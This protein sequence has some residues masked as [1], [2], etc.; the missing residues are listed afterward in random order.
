MVWFWG[1]IWLRTT[2]RR[3][4]LEQE[5]L[6]YITRQLQRHHRRPGRRRARRPARSSIP[7]R[8]P[9]GP[10]AERRRHLDGRLRRRRG[11][12]RRASSPPC[13]RPILLRLVPDLPDDVQG[14]AD[15]ADLRGGGG[16]P[17][18]ARPAALR[19]LLAQHRRS[20]P[21]L[22]RRDRAHQLHRRRAEYGGKHFVYLSKYMEPDH[23]Y[24]TMPEE[25][26]DRDV[27]AL[28]AAINP[29]F[30]RVW[31]ERWWV[32]RERAAQPIVTLNYSE[33]LPDHR[34]ALQQ[35]L[36]RQHQPDLPGRPRHQLQRPPR[37][38]DRRP[39]DRRSRRPDRKCGTGSSHGRRPIATHRSDL[40]HFRYHLGRT[41][42]D[43]IPTGLGRDR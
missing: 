24:F 40:T 13:R 30:D 29:A 36:P 12:L 22:H 8:G 32:F 42:T 18:P 43:A 37:Q 28:P 3:S 38:P 1:K 20:G 21:A 16:R 27:P 23:P 25:R 34:T 19:H 10:P 7:G 35:S 15:R 31:I 14:E 26:A 5:K 4:P 39:R 33:K 2:S 9:S 17:A 41:A 6:G 11:P